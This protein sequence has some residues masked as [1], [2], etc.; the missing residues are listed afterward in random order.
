MN[1]K[2]AERDILKNILLGNVDYDSIER[3]DMLNRLSS[4]S[5]DNFKVYFDSPY[6]GIYRTTLGTLE[7]RSAVGDK[8]HLDSEVI[9]NLSKQCEKALPFLYMPDRDVKIEECIDLSR[10]PIHSERK[11]VTYYQLAPTKAYDFCVQILKYK[12]KRSII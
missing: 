5:D 2:K 11:G 3:I 4:R 6:F 9:E 10:Y 1:I 12:E 7:V 8:I